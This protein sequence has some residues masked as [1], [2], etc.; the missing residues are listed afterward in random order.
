M[1]TTLRNIAAALLITAAAQTAI[2]QNTGYTDPHS[3][4]TR[5]LVF[6]RGDFNSPF[7]RIPAIT[8]L[9]GGDLGILTEEGLHNVDRTHQAGYRIWFTRIP[10]ES[11]IK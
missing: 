8:T 6:N 5:S 4:I 3:G 11:I 1:K 7:Y 2:A 10:L 9:P